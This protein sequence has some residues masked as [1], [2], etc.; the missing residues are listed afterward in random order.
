MPGIFP[1]KNRYGVRPVDFEKENEV[2]TA[3]LSGKQASVELHRKLKETKAR[4]EVIRTQVAFSTSLGFFQAQ[5]FFLK[6]FAR[7]RKTS[8]CGSVHMVT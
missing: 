4:G 3:T 8:C 1:P 6:L 2:F 5:N 7:K